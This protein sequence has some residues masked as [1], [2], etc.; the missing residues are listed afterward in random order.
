MTTIIVM[1]DDQEIDTLDFPREMTTISLGRRPTN[2]VHLADRSVSG[3][4][5]RLDI[6]AEAITLEDLSSTNGTYL[7]GRPVQRSVIG[8]D[9][10]VLVG[11]VQ[12]QITPARQ[13]AAG[14]ADASNGANPVVAHAD[15]DGVAASADESMLPGDPDAE[16]DELDESMRAALAMYGDDEPP[17]AAAST[18]SDRQDRDDEDD[19]DFSEDARLFAQGTGATAGGEDASASFAGA[20]AAS[21]AAAG[22]DTAVDTHSLSARAKVALGR[23]PAARSHLHAVPHAEGCAD[24]ALATPARRSESS[25]ARRGRNHPIDELPIVPTHELD[26]PRP[27]SRGA[28]IEI[29]NGAKSGQILPIDKP[30][31]TLGR[32]GIQI[33][34]IMRKPDGY[35]LMHI[36]SDDS[37][38]RPT[39]NADLIGDEPV[40][41]HSGDELNVA[42]ID[43]E[44]MLS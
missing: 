3:N 38:D 30:V 29:K 7:N 18:P 25:D 37:V 44:F 26:G 23:E 16:D 31:T 43:V 21:M 2:D 35:F 4:H 9:D 33:A 14:V 20:E 41:L 22:G 17:A 15:D 27:R 39:L 24:T 19:I 34:A 13:D 28:V 40:L 42:G 8:P 32:P 11:K 1:H 10:E 12:L 36:E 5:A 6:T